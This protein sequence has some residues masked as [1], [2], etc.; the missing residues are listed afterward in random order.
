MFVDD[1]LPNSWEVTS[2]SIAAYIAGK[3]EADKL[4]LVKD[5]DGIF[6]DDPKLNPNAK[7]LDKVTVRE[8]IGLKGKTCVDAYLPKLLEKLYIQCQVL[9]GFHP[10]RVEAVLSGQ[11][12]VGTSI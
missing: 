12:T 2:D 8:L 5:V 6:D 9:N 4:L 11:K 3:L 10:E 1:G 7:L